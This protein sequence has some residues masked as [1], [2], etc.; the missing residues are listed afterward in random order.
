MG[1]AKVENFTGDEEQPLILAGFLPFRLAMT[2][3]AVSRLM[4][5]ACE[6]RLGL[7]IPQSRVLCIL[8][9]QANLTAGVIDARSGLDRYEIEEAVSALALR[10]LLRRADGGFFLTADGHGLQA[11]LASLA[12]AAEAALVAGLAPE[13]VRST[14][15][16]LGRLETAALKLSGRATAGEHCRPA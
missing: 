15:R 11:E 4:S 8:A 14:H 3:Q 9:E 1:I 7:D 10:G 16:L 12:L 6:E 5:R 2:A 13:D